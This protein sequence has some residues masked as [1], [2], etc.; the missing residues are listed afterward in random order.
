MHKINSECVLPSP[1]S[2]RRVTKSNSRKL[3]W[4]WLRFQKDLSC[5]CVTWVKDGL[6]IRW[7]LLD[8]F[9]KY[10][11]LVF[12]LRL[13]RSPTR[14]E[15]EKRKGG[16]E[17]ER[18]STTPVFY[19]SHWVKDRQ[20]KS[21][22]ESQPLFHRYR[23]LCMTR[24]KH[25]DSFIGESTALSSLK[26]NSTPVYEGNYGNECGGGTEQEEPEGLGFT[27]CT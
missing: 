11:K 24:I 14:R 10:L 21:A 13:L 4:E 1:A 8:F 16:V 9:F 17:G 26:W 6:H 22:S 3:W 20:T 27:V 15:R 2:S 23:Q 5:K 12:F 7:E 18:Q 19:H 25:S